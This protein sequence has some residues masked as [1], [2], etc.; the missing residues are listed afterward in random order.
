MRTKTSEDGADPDRAEVADRIHSAAIHLLRGV[1]RG[2]S[3]SGLSPARLSVLSVLVFRGRVSMGELAEA[4]QVS[5]PTISRM[6]A[7]LEQAGLVAREKDARDHRIVYLTA[8]SQG[9]EILQQARTRR[10][11][12]LVNR[13][14]ALSSADVRL[15]GRAADILEG[16]T[17]QVDATAP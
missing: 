12:T 10:I 4:E 3:E 5:L 6:V 14:E 7:A 11:Q 9:T 13:L 15:I 16:I 17:A 1:R 2:D 8:T